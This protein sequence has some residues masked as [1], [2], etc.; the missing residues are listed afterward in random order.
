MFGRGTRTVCDLPETSP[1]ARRAAIAASSKPNCLVL[2][3]G[4]ILAT[5]GPIDEM[6]PPVTDK[7]GR[8]APEE[9]RIKICPECN[10][11]NAEQ[12]E[13][14]KH[15]GQ[16]FPK[17]VRLPNHEKK[18]DTE[19]VILS[20]NTKDYSAQAHEVFV[21]NDT[22]SKWV[23]VTRW[24]FS[25][26]KKSETSPDYLRITYYCGICLTINEA[27]CFDH[28]P[29]LKA[30]AF[31]RWMDLSGKFSFSPSSVKDA[32]ERSRELIMPARIKIKKR[33]KYY[34]V[35][36]SEAPKEVANEAAA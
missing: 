11:I 14:C 28:G 25:V 26:S 23:N 16:E 22:T 20:V 6:E 36:A 21:E 12:A 30:K 7:K 1:E 5:H 17:T 19:S 32:F 31:S 34:N 13:R 24:R 15:C 29:A 3:F 18:A 9:K 33:G 2:D 10:V 4:R 27:F 8:K 35:L